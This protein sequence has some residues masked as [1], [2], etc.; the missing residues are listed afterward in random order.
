MSRGPSTTGNSKA[1]WRAVGGFALLAIAAVSF[2]VSSFVIRWND[3]LKWAQELRSPLIRLVEAHPVTASAAF[4]A[5]YVAFTALALPG[6]VI[7]SLIGGAV[8]GTLW[9]VILVSF[10]STT[11]A[12]LACLASRYL[13][14]NWVVA[15]YG[16]RLAS[17]Q[18]ELDR[19]GVFYLLSL[20]L[21]PVFPYFLINLFFG[22]TRMPVSRFWLVSQIGMLPATIIYVNAG[23]QLARIDSLRDVLRWEVA[24]SLIALSLFPIVARLVAGWLRRI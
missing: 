18:R 22:L 17:I 9:G 11:G 12:T 3:V 7:L 1:R 16:D 20:R 23:A 2:I 4:F 8:F 21:N 6:A 10:A 5:L 19:G 24:A 15:R 14:R 13:L